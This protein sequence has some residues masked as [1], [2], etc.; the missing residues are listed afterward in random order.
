MIQVCIHQACRQGETEES[1]PEPHDVWGT[2]SSP[3]NIFA[4]CSTAKLISRANCE[5]SARYQVGVVG[6]ARNFVALI[7]NR[8]QRARI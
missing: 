3:Q 6:S 7:G 1:F 2:P 5:V 8:S 4:I